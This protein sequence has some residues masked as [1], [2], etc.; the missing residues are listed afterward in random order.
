MRRNFQTVSLG[1]RVNKGIERALRAEREAPG[2]RSPRGLHPSTSSCC[3]LPCV[4]Y[5]LTIPIVARRPQLGG[6]V[7]KSSQV[8]LSSSSTEST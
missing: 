4:T 3:W 8:V 5:L 1:S 6:E 7:E 2:G